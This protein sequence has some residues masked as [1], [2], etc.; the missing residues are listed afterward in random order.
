MLLFVLG[1][2]H[3]SLIHG[4]VSPA[5]PEDKTLAQLSDILKKHCDPKAIVIAERFHFYQDSKIRQISC[6]LSGK[7]K[8]TSQPVQVWRFPFRSIERPTCLQ[9]KQ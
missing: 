5:K 7:S 8:K 1:L 3:Y 6:R 4:L 2:R 9:A